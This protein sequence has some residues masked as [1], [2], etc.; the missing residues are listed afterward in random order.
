M[1]CFL[2]GQTSFRNCAS[3]A[4]FTVLNQLSHDIA[5]E[6]D[7]NG[8]TDADVAVATAVLDGHVNADQFARQ[9]HQRPAGIAEIDRGIGLDEIFQRFNTEAGSTERQNDT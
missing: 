7:W 9:I 4:N 2:P 8:K 1:R 5:G 6:I 3:A